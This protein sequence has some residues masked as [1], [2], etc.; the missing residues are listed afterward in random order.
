MK[1]ETKQLLRD[2]RVAAMLGQPEAIDIALNGLLALPG[3]ASNDR[4]SDGLIEQVVL[5]D[6]HSGQISPAGLG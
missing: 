4:M 2:L 6:L 3:V 1:H 5:P